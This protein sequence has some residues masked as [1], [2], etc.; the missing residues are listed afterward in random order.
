MIVAMGVMSALSMA[1]T[2]Y[3]IKSQND[4]AKVSA[5]S[6]SNAAAADYQAISAAAEQTN[7]A[8]NAEALKMKRQ[9]LIERGRLIAAQSEAGFIGNSPLR[10]LL[11]QRL[12][13]QEALGALETNQANALAQN[14][15]EANK[16]FITAQSRY[17]DAKSRRVSG[18]ASGLMIAS[19]GMQGAASGYSLYN[20]LTKPKKVA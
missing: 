6:A 9:A 5:E 19:A 3:G 20:G 12:K 10:E 18:V 13:E 2:A 1:T 15:R 14:S 17:N 16:V 4:Q 8:A 7:A 11:N